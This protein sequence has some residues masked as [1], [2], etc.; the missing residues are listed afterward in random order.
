MSARGM[1][2]TFLLAVPFRTVPY[3]FAPL[4][5]SRT[6]LSLVTAA[7]RD[8]AMFIIVHRT[9][10]SNITLIPHVRLGYP[11]GTRPSPLSLIMYPNVPTVNTLSGII[12]RCAILKIGH[13]N[14][15]EKLLDFG[16]RRARGFVKPIFPNFSNTRTL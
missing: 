15:Q 8:V 1:P 7:S 5:E 12:S 10:S 9:P 16:N 4:P 11:S 13:G 2:P 6:V 3:R 14:A